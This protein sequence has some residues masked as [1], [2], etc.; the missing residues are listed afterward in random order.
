[1]TNEHYRRTLY[2]ASEAQQ[3][4]LRNE[5]MMDS[6]GRKITEARTGVNDIKTANELGMTLDDYMK[7]IG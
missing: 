6:R 5:E 1:M 7:M 2:S 4:L 3:V